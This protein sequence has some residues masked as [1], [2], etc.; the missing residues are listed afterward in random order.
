MD[1]PVVDVRALF[2]RAVPSEEEGSKMEQVLHTVINNVDDINAVDDH[3]GSL[4][5]SAIQV[6]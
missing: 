3:G 6:K 1:V 2:E 4:L 5:H